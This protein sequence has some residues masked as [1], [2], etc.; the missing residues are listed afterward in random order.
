MKNARKRATTLNQ[1]AGDERESL[2][3]Y[4][5][6]RIVFVTKDSKLSPEVRHAVTTELQVALLFAETRA[7][8]T[9]RRGGIGKK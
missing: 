4:L 6:R 5:K 1:G 7:K 9:R 3:D 8:R 2:K